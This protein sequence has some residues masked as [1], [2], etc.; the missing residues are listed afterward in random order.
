MQCVRATVRPLLLLACAALLAIGGCLGAYHDGLPA[1]SPPAGQSAASVGYHWQYSPGFGFGYLTPGAR[2]GLGQPPLAADFGFTSAVVVGSGVAVAALG[3]VIGIGYQGSSV[4]FMLR[5]SAYLL[6]ISTS[7]VGFFSS[8]QASLL[9]GNSVQA[10]KTH[11]SGGGRFSQHTVGPVLL[12]GHSLGALDLR[13]EGSF[14][15]GT[16][17]SEQTRL[18]VGLTVGGPA[19]Q[20]EEEPGM[21]GY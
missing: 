6:G 13:L 16:L 10:G 20:A 8:W 17:D 2:I 7:G 1:W 12:I 19:P 5:P 4:S 21:W 11:I 14:Q 15:F 18:T 9:A 3:P